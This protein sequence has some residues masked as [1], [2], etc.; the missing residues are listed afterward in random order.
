MSLPFVLL[1]FAFSYVPLFGWIYAFTDYK[2]GMRFSDLSFTGFRAFGTFFMGSRDFGRVMRNTM[3]M[4]GLSLI[5]TPLPVLFAILLNEIRSTRYRRLVQTLTTLPNFI[6]WI[7]VFSLCFA[8]FAS[9]G[10]LNMTLIRLG[11]EPVQSILAN[12]DAVWG[13]QWALG[14][15]KSLGWG[16]I[17]YIAAIAG[18][19]TQL[20]EAA[21][22]DGANRFQR[23]IHVTL[24][25]LSNT[26]I[27]LLL[28]GIGNILRNGFE[29][30][31][32]FHNPLV[33]DRIQVL[34]YYVYRVGLLMNDYPM[35]TALG[36][37]MTLI[38]LT[39]LF[40]A[41]GASK[42]IRGEAI[43]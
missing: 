12:N 25:G 4:S 36:M 15:W 40:L 31:Y 27:V 16:A 33:S 32:V 6:S 42:R 20:Y 14:T 8:I 5:S 30:F 21:Q 18:I 34:D 29:Q 37:A 7:I 39:I 23:I 10:M 11:F 1:I 28:L 24:P 41:N 9:N 13:F 3:V 35:S 17:I 2:P 22:I 19:D 26:Y 38:S 43:F